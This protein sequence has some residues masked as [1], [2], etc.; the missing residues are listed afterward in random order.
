MAGLSGVLPAVS[1]QAL[2]KHG[3]KIC[4]HCYWNKDR[5]IV[6]CTPGS[7]LFLLPSWD[8]SVKIHRK[9]QLWAIA[10]ATER[11]SSSYNL[12]KKETIICQWQQNFIFWGL[13][14]WTHTAKSICWWKDKK[15][16]K[17]T[18]T[19]EFLLPA[20][21]LWQITACCDRH[22]LMT[23][24]KVTQCTSLYSISFIKSQIDNKGESQPTT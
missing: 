14:S 20:V 13:H 21:F 2:T 10:T 5:G 8:F 7:L 16:L 18:S 11:W 22:L 1:E 24:V 15:S 12:Q 4:A 9:S 3:P 19:F 23:A 17:F 6:N